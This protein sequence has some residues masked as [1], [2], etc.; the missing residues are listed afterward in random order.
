MVSPTTIRVRKGDKEFVINAMDKLLPQ[1]QGW[2]V[3]DEMGGGGGSANV[4]TGDSP[5]AEAEDESPPSR[6]GRKKKAP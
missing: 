6:A 3:V 4:E 1:W 5:S 2:S